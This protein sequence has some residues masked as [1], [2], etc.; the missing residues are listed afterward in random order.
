MLFLS[1]TVLSPTSTSES[2]EKQFSGDSTMDLRAERAYEEFRCAKGPMIGSTCSR[3]SVWPE[4]WREKA[5]GRS[6]LA[7]T[8]LIGGAYLVV[9][10]VH[11]EEYLEKRLSL[12]VGEDLLAR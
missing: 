5:G 3:I 11:G 10:W 1:G 9:R 7:P 4:Y 8:C 12:S 6:G 2:A